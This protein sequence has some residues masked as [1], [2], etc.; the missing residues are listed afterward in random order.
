MGLQEGPGR[1]V[2][3]L[4]PPQSPGPPELYMGRS[5]SQEKGPLNWKF[6]RGRNHG[7]LGVREPGHSLGAGGA[8]PRAPGAGEAPKRSRAAAL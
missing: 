8:S 4:F 5:G 6:R 3:G 1:T 7:C 2:T